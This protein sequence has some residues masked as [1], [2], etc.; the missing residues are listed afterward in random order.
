MVKSCPAGYFL[1]FFLKNLDNYRLCL[2]FHLGL[3]AS[4]FLPYVSHL[5]KKNWATCTYKDL[6]WSSSSSSSS[7]WS[8]TL[9][10]SWVKMHLMHHMVIQSPWFSTVWKVLSF[11]TTLEPS[12][13]R[14]WLKHY[15]GERSCH[16]S[17]TTADLAFGG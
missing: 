2:L 1:T 6:T 7:G 16:C 17:L 5:K 14:T 8:Y 15:W 10:A 11:T 13:K 4:H 3:S 9:K 12:A